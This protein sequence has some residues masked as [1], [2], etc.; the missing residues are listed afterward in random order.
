MPADPAS[1]ALVE[2][3]RAIELRTV[4]DRPLG[5][6]LSGGIDS[7]AVACRLAALGHGDLRTFTAAFDDPR[8][9]ESAEAAATARTLGLPNLALPVP[10]RIGP[11]SSAS[12]RTWTSRS[13]TLRLPDMD[14]GAR[15][16]R[17][18]R[19]RPGRRRRRR[20]AG[21]LQALRQAPA[22]G[23]A[24]RPVAAGAAGRVAR[25]AGRGA[26][27]RRDRAAL[28]RA[29]VLRFSGFSPAQRRFLQGGDPLARSTWWRLPDAAAVAAAAAPDAPRGLAE[30]IAIDLANYLPEY[31]LRKGRSLHDGARAGAARAAARPPLRAGRGGAAGGAAIHRSAQAAAAPA[32]A[33]LAALD[34]FGRKKRG[35]NPPLRAWLADDLAPRLDGLGERL[36]ALSAGGWTRPRSTRSRLPGAAGATR[37]PS[38]CCSC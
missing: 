6:F 28:A 18:C 4:A 1:A 7:T 37:S 29:Y 10:T 13:P 32:L 5:V 27:G 17:A 3:D 23:L 19:R 14:S 15:R 30:L 9:D 16:A 8:F 31:V 11:T 25:G 21:R 22:H 35:F 33:P 26:L 38:R 2:L 12:S 36:S 24:P 34:P 20:A